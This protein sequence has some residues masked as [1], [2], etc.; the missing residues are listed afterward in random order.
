MGWLLTRGRIPY[1]CL[2]ACTTA[3]LGFHATCV[4][5][6]RNNESLNAR[7][8]SLT[9]A[10]DQFRAT[11]GSDEDLLLAVTHARLL[12]ADGLRLLDD[13]TGRIARLDGV[14]HAYSLSN[15]QRLVSSDIGAQMAPLIARPADA[16]D[17]RAA[18]ADHPELTGLFIS[19]NRRTAGIVIEIED[20]P[21]DHHYRARLIDALRELIETERRD[22]LEL[23]LT[24]IA[25]Q[26]HDVS[27]FIEH[28]QRVLMPLAVVI[29]GA[30]LTVFFRRLL[31]VL[32]PLAVTGISVAWTMGVYQ[33]AGLS[34]NAITSLLPPILMVLSLAVSVHIVHGWLEAP[35]PLGPRVPRLLGVLRKLLFP[36]FFCTLTTAVGFGSLATSSIPAVQQLGVFAAFGVVVAFVIG[37]TL[38]PIG[39]TFIAPPPTPPSDPQDRAVEA[40]LGWAAHV[41][42]TYPWRIVLIFGVI[43][44]VSLLGFPLI[45]NNT[46]LVRFL[47]SD[48][49]LFRD[50]MFIDTHLT[51]ANTLEIIVSRQDDK[52]LTGLDDLRHMEL[53][54]GTIDRHD[55]VTG[56]SSVLPILRQ[57]QRAEGGLDRLRLPDNERDTAH[58]FDLLEAAP[59]QDLI[60]K[61]ISADFKRVRFNV[62]IHAVGTAVAVPLAEAIL[63]DARRTFGWGYTVKATG[64][65]YQV[66]TTS[67]QLVEA[68]VHSFALAL[69]LV[70]LAI[71]VLFRSLRL[72]IIALI[73]NVM[74]IV[75]TGGIMGFFGIDL[76]TGT[77]MIASAVIGL[78]VDDTI[79]YLT[80]FTRAYRDDTDDAVRRTTTGVGAPLLVN[81]F[82]LVLG[83]WV[84]AFGSFKPTI[85]FSLLSGITMITALMCDLFVTPACLKLLMPGR[86]NT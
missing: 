50:T 4:D 78:V 83:F 21:D 9:T 8:E 11:F 67:N 37:M 12:E 33:L 82:V 26:K 71:G 5:I 24:G 79:H 41:S 63:D 64:A 7:D 20:R 42:V 62:R 22:D 75:W 59:E 16:P 47:K 55:L 73:P 61:V 39:L 34:M 51:G 36:C 28:D 60:R 25:V 48:A 52:P 86:S 69:G 30:V 2:V 81:N 40:A 3:W 66:A 6:E 56:V 54:E 18:L 35:D 19:A 13:L 43:T 68:Q 29:L 53:F 70:V 72:T 10:Y 85:Y 1:L 45:R 38:V 77:A 65:F 32:L 17:L 14:R 27:S 44:G 74:P 84:G 80:H 49:P 57:L 23:H 15:A 76:S 58:A 31:A 46:D